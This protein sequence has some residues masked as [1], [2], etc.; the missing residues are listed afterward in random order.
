MFSFL[1]FSPIFSHSPISA[2]IISGKIVLSLPA[3]FAENPHGFFLHEDLNING[4]L[5]MS[6]KKM[7]GLSLLVVSILL[8]AACTPKEAA[9]PT[10]DPNMVYTQA[11]ETV[12]AQLTS[13]A[14]KEPTIDPNKIRT[15]A[16]QTVA[17]EMAQKATITPLPTLAQINTLAPLPAQAQP[18]APLP[19]T[20]AGNAAEWRGQ[21][22]VD[23]TSVSVGIDTDAYWTLKN[24]GTK[25]WTK[26]YQYRF[27]LGDGQFHK[28]KA[29]FLPKDVLPGEEITITVD[30]KANL[31]NGNYYEMWVLTDENGVNF[32]QFDVRF[33]VGGAAPTSAATKA[34]ISTLDYYCI[35]YGRWLA[36]DARGITW[37]EGLE[38]DKTAQGS[39]DWDWQDIE[40]GCIKAGTTYKR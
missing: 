8:L 23:G 32:S 20:S 10:P 12:A 13:Q 27:Y 2:F 22:P 36:P 5:S 28:T 31:P 3:G 25:T 15:E 21:W 34:P 6:S 40:A 38:I 9:E 39:A 18:T 19:S 26:Q 37:L 1:Y 24:I 17:A 29:Y 33:S 16:A 35:Y 7:I 4:G 11:A 30:M 14:P